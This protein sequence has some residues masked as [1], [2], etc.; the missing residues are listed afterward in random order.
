MRATGW[1]ASRS[2]TRASRRTPDR[3]K[4]VRTHPG[5]RTTTSGTLADPDGVLDDEA[6]EEVLARSA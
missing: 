1:S 5:T 3:W 4:G 6:A 2:T